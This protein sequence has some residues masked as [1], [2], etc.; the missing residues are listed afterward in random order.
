ITLLMLYYVYKWM[1]GNSN[2]PISVPWTY[3]ESA[4]S[5]RILHTDSLQGSAQEERNPESAIMNELRLHELIGLVWVMISPA[6]AGYTLYYSRY[7]LN[8][9]QHYINSFNI[10]VFVFGASVKPLMHLTTLLRERTIYLQKEIH[11]TGRELGTVE[12]RLNLIE[13]ELKE[14]RHMN[15]SKKHMRQTTRDI[16]LDL[17]QLSNS[18][19]KFESKEV[20][21]HQWYERSFQSLN[22][23]L[24]E[25]DAF[26]H[27]RMETPHVSFYGVL[28][29]LTLLP[30]T[31]VLWT[32]HRMIGLLPIPHK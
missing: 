32:L 2:D 3:Y 23:K 6:I 7:V 12:K 1:T 27:G 14:I 10:T 21:M 18:M 5:R 31:M 22:S 30:F 9:H 15:V 4:R 16:G 11:D 29:S 17:Q 28:I 19:H 8:H 13:K 26:F 24:R 25:F 20:A